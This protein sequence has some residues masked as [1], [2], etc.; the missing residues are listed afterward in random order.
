MYTHNMNIE[1]KPTWGEEIT[2]YFTGH[3]KL[4]HA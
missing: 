4:L 3:T 2:K 1:Y